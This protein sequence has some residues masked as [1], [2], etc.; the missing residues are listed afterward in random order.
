M[1]GVQ[2]CALPISG[3][4]VAAWNFLRLSRL[5]DDA[6]LTQ[7]AERQLES[8]AG[9][10]SAYPSGHAMFLIALDFAYSAPREVVIVGD[11]ADETTRRMIQTARG[12][13]RPHELIVFVPEGAEGERVRRIVPP[14]KDKTA[15][16][17]RP[18]AYV[19]ENFMCHAPTTDVEKL[20]EM[21]A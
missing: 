20:A 12:G 10:V 2:T 19:C 15:I 8:F 4:S 11:P 17:G 3:N 18:T 1:T 21:L 13:Y 9:A 16:G 7:I 5:T 6:Q 14:V